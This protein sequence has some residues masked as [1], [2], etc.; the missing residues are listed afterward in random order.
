LVLDVMM[1]RVSG[2]EVLRQVRADPALATLPVLV[3]SAYPD[4]R[5]AAEAL[6]ATFI[7]KPWQAGEL[8]RVAS[9][10]LAGAARPERKTA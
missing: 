2:L 5:Q 4:N 1:P 7:A 8:L 9:A 6:G 10:L 3:S